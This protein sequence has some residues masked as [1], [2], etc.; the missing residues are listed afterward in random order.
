VL[1]GVTRSSAL[2]VVDVQ[3]DFCCEGGAL[4]VP[5]CEGIVPRINEYLRMFVDAGLLVIASRDWHPPNHIS[6]KPYGGPWPPHCIQGSWGAEFHPGLELP[7]DVYVVSKAY[8]RDKEAYSA[9][10]GTELHYVLSTR[11][12]RRLFVTGV[13]TDYCVKAT[14]LDGLRLGYEVVVLTDAVAAVSEEGGVRALEE[15]L[16]AGAILADLSSVKLVT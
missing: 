16:K 10:D 3:K 13:A 1:V 8:L 6:F 11:G 5:G 12:V 15:M 9:F 14:V 4:R 7:S 2:I